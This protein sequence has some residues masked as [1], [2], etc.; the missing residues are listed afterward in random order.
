MQPN[1]IHDSVREHYAE[2]ARSSNSCCG[3][4]SNTLYD[5]QLIQAVPADISSFSLGCGDPITLAHLKPGETVLDLGSGGGLDCFLASKQV[6][7]TGHVIG[8]DMTPDMLAK[9]RANAQRLGYPNVEFREGYLEALPV[10]EASIDVV[11]SNCVI[12]LSP[13]KPQV[14]REVFR[15][16]R[17]P[18]A[19]T[20]KPGGRVAVSDIVTNGTLP[21][22]VQQSM[23]AWG[24]CVAGALDA[25]EYVRGLS[26]A[27]FVN[28][29]VQPKSSADQALAALPIGLP[30]SAT[31]TADKPVSGQPIG[32][33]TVNGRVAPIQFEAG[34]FDALLS[35]VVAMD[36]L[37]DGY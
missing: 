17:S 6:G 30:F 1:S 10:D 5:E 24:A 23:A 9:A 20:G 7:A 15:V 28:V 32:D 21:Q 26:E 25:Q 11:I 4:S 22:S 29:R 35:Q 27:G 14:F 18:D 19:V 36:A 12:N 37:A 16:L 33:L 8:V 31:I 13:D 2:L 3:S 34:R